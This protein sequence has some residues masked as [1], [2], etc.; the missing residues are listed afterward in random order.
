LTAKEFFERDRVD[1]VPLLTRMLARG[2]DTV[3]LDGNSPSTAGL[4]V[5][6]ARELGCKGRFVRTGGPATAEIL[7]VAGKDSSEGIHGQVQDGT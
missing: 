2:I 5:K 6:Q 4:I 1:F 3:E 7:S